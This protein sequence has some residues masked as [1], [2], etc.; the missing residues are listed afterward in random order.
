[1]DPA[2]EDELNYE[3]FVPRDFLVMNGACKYARMH[4][5][6]AVRGRAPLRRRCRV[7]Y[8]IEM[9]LRRVIKLRD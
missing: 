1:M 5:K 3:S 8:F 6:T 2:R 4:N 9:C 7:I